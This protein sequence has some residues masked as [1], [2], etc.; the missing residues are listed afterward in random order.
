M[1]MSIVCFMGGIKAKRQ[2]LKVLLSTLAFFLKKE[3]YF[4][5][6]SFIAPFYIF[7]PSADFL[8]CQIEQLTSIF[9]LPASRNNPF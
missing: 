1:V 3:T 4:P 5:F 9:H 2:G 8:H 7:L 6:S